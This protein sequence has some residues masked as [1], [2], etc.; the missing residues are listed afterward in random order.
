MGIFEQR[1][2]GCVAVLPELVH[3]P[4]GVARARAERGNERRSIQTSLPWLLYKPAF[5]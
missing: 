5:R 2:D 3:I 4:L 1:G